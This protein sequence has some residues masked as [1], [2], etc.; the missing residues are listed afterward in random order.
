[1]RRRKGKDKPEQEQLDQLRRK[2][3]RIAIGTHGPPAAEDNPKRK[4]KPSGR[5][6]WRSNHQ[7][8]D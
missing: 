8:E 6:S 4:W 3:E 7:P 5:K 2:F 1:M